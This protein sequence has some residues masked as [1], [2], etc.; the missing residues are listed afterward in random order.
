MYYQIAV[1]HTRS[2]MNYFGLFGWYF[3]IYLVCYF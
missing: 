1:I 3:I 2:V